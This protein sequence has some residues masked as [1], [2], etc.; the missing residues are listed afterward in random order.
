VV[1][2]P[3]AAKSSPTLTLTLSASS[4]STGGSVHATATLANADPTAGGT[5]MYAVYTDSTCVTSAAAALQP[6]PA[7]VTVAAGVAPASATVTFPSAG[8]F[9][10]QAAYVGDANDT[11][12]TSACAS[13]QLTVGS[14]EQLVV[15]PKQGTSIS[16]Q[17]SASSIRPGDGVHDSAT[18]IGETSTAGGSVSYAYY[19]DNAC[20]QNKVKVGT[21]Q[22]T[23][24]V[25]PSSRTI[26]FSTPGTYYWQAVYSGDSDNKS[27][28]SPCTSGSNEQL[29]VAATGQPTS[30]STQLSVTTIHTGETATDTATLTGATATAGG[31]IS[32]SYFTDNACTH[33]RVKAGSLPVANGVPAPSRRMTFPD[34][35]T[36]YWRV[37]YS[38]DAANQPSVSACNE[39]L[40]VLAKQAVTVTTQLSATTIPAGGSATDRA[41]LGGATTTAGGSVSYSYWADSSC[42]QGR[43]RAGTVQVANGVAPSSKVM[44]FSTPGTYYWRAVYSGDTNNQSAASP[45]TPQSNEQLTVTSST[46]NQPVSVT[47]QLSATTIY[48]GGSASDT[49]T[50]GGA[51]PDAVGAV[52]Y[53]YYT[54]NICTQGQQRVGTVQ[55]ANR[56]VP[57]SKTITFPAAGTYY[58][59]A[60]Y[61]GDPSN[62]RA[63]SPCTAASN[64]QLTVLPASSRHRTSISTQLSATVIRVGESVHDS[65]TLA[66]ESGDAGGS[67]TYSYYTDSSCTQNQVKVGSVPVTNGVVP[68]SKTVTFSS[69]GTVYWQA[70][71][72]GDAANLPSSSPCDRIPPIL[73]TA[74]SAS[75][76]PAGGAAHDTATLTGATP[77][78][79]GTVTY[80]VYT[81]NQCTSTAPAALQPSPATVTVAN[82]QVPPSADVVF[83]SAGVFYWQAAYSGDASNFSVSSACAPGD[84][85]QLT[86]TAGKAAPTVSTQ[87]SAPSIPAGGTAHDSA[88]LTGATASA[89]GTLTYAV[90]TSNT[91]ATLAAGLQPA[92]ATVTVT[93]AH[94][95]DSA[96]VTF[97]S[98]G[99]F[100]WRASYSG[101][102]GNSAAASPCTA[103]GNE[104]L[105]VT[106]GKLSPTVA[107]QLSQVSIETGGSAHDS[108]TL[109]GATPAAGGTVTYA[110]YT[111]STCATQAAGVQPSPATATVTNGHVP[112]SANVTFP[113]AG[114]FYWRASYSGDANNNAASSP[115][116]P[117]DNEQLTVTAQTSP[118]I[119]TTL[120]KSTIHKGESAKDTAQLTGAGPDPDG[121][122]VYTVYADSSCTSVY[123]NA[124]VIVGAGPD[125][126]VHESH[127]VH[128]DTPGTYYWQAVYS[129]DM[130]HGPAASPC[131]SEILVVTP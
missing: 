131:G 69:P 7:L 57:P 81:D 86:V 126:K 18:L 67:V 78:A 27:S 44:G 45:C 29:T 104:Q 2:G 64:E 19:S 21:V 8:T 38:G 129:G 63:S 41:T 94:V 101:D 6:S 65:S 125:G 110:V 34:A 80:V 47:T 114:T 10:W 9:Y 25:V 85:E 123:A 93:T 117:S 51:T 54:N 124:G 15:V 112:D 5:L 79:G 102:A 37:T 118:S 33:G 107:T 28:S 53:S 43:V 89:G 56:T 95:P 106:T 71:Y 17:L 11:A 122:V 70:V 39:V 130:D 52:S 4:V 108:T 82:G 88:T 32:Y 24:G 58:W 48:E 42:T 36:F 61:S 90:Y 73:T 31:T 103:A 92:P 30:L 12:A 127:E 105:T 50:L 84:D 116:T 26:V 121:Y 128:F 22:V 97:P 1:A 66:G 115:C 91:C 68:D 76:I 20:S 113:S 13:G 83:P 46:G 87:L 77:D 55:V 62:Q 23:N 60:V 99:T 3:A 119:A 35:G 14:G 109:T 96:S 120:S 59:Q 72:S 98:A 16:T 100:Y 111:S 49:A 40:T 75:T 74:L